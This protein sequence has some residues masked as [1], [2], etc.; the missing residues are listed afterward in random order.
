MAPDFIRLR[1]MTIFNAKDTSVST[2]FIIYESTM[3]MILE[4]PFGL[5]LGT[6]VYQVFLKDYTL[7]NPLLVVAHS[8]NIFLQIWAEQGILALISFFV[9]IV[10]LGV[11]TLWHNK[12]HKLN[13]H[14]EIG[15]A[16]LMG[17]LEFTNNLKCVN[18][19]NQVNVFTKSKKLNN[20]M[21]ASL[22]AILS[23]IVMGFA[24]HI[25]FYFRIQIMIWLNICILFMCFNLQASK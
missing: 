13:K 8:H 19:T 12:L 25:W 23:I 11:K 15:D 22:S 5:G 9:M 4:N 3:R 18:H 7:F 6:S 2:R 21:I 14:L 17:D 16:N 1:I 20:I 10:S 24:E